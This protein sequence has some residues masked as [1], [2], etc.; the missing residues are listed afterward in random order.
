[1][2]WSILSANIETVWYE[3]GRVQTEKYLSDK[4]VADRYG[5]GR[6]TPWRWVKE[7]GFPPPI[8]FSAGCSRWNLLAI[9]DWEKRQA[10][11]TIARDEAKV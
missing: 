9:V 1:V 8:K 10:A 2:P 4:E 7:V 11:Q 6:A 5:V 3:I